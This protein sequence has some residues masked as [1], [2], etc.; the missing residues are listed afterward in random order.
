MPAKDKQPQGVTQWRLAQLIHAGLP[1]P[2]ASRV[3]RD[4]RYDLHELI[5]LVEHGC[6]PA[7]AVR[8]VQ[9]LE[10]DQAA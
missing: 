6:T 9:P 2:L 7:L 5:Q 10:K 3:A 8:I 4:E 1:L